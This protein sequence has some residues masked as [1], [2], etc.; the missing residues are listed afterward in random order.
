MLENYFARFI[1]FLR[2]LRQHSKKLQIKTNRNK[3]KMISEFLKFR[4]YKPQVPFF[5]PK[6]Y[7]PKLLRIN[8]PCSVGSDSFG[9]EHAI[10]EKT[11]AEQDKYKQEIV[12]EHLKLPIC[13]L[14]VA[15]RQHDTTQILSIIHGL[16]V[17]YRIIY[18]HCFLLLFLPCDDV[19]VAVGNGFVI[20]VT[21]ICFVL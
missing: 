2:Y 12:G 11:I 7:R 20:V 18:H 9:F 17:Q 16:V 21:N 15:Q 14:D 19:A 5:C 3:F 1:K 13:C 10:N 6:V 4:R 8:L